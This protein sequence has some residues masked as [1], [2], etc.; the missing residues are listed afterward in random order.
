MAW[1]SRKRCKNEFAAS[2]DHVHQAID[3]SEYQCD[4]IHARYLRVAHNAKAAQLL[5]Q[6]TTSLSTD[7][8]RR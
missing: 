5:Q 8:V 2:I 1:M 7:I 6:Q 4:F 3:A